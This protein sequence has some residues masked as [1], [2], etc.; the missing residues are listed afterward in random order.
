[1]AQLEVT[2]A[3]LLRP[4]ILPSIVHR[5]RLIVRLGTAPPASVAAPVAHMGRIRMNE[6]QA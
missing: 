2:E 3:K 4:P 6:M 5:T 1:M